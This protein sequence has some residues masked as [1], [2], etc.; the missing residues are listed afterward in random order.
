METPTSMGTNVEV[1]FP[2]KARKDVPIVAMVVPR[3]IM[4]VLGDTM[5]VSGVAMDV[6]VGWS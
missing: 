3:D 1:R 2:M 5:G 4:D 6:P